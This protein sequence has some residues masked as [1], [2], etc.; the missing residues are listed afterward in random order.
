MAALLILSV[1]AVVVVNGWTD[2]PGALTTVICA[3][4]LPP[5]RAVGLVAAANAVGIVVAGLLLP[6]VADTMLRLAR[7]GAGT[8]GAVL[9][10][11]VLRSLDF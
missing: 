10:C 6:R 1:T 4:A 9:L 7:F 3:K 5:R 8:A 11:W 2:A